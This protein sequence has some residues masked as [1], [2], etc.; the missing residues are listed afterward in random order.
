MEVQSLRAESARSAC[1]PD[2]LT[3]TQTQ[4]SLQHLLTYWTYIHTYSTVSTVHTTKRPLHAGFNLE[5]AAWIAQEARVHRLAYVVRASMYVCTELYSTCCRS[6]SPQQL[7][8]CRKALHEAATY[9]M[10][11]TYIQ[12]SSGLLQ[13]PAV[14][15]NA[16]SSAARTALLYG[17]GVML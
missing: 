15:P 14:F 5:R 17:K 2:R 16:M 3:R 9:S 12:Y 13:V 7:A 4:A 1:R 11:S 10:Y 6:I 8:S